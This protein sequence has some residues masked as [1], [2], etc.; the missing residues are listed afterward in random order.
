MSSPSPNTLRWTGLAA[1]WLA[2]AGCDPKVS[3]SGASAGYGYKDA[4]A[5]T[6]SIDPER[7]DAPP[8]IAPGPTLPT[9]DAAETAPPMAGACP[10]GAAPPP[11]SCATLGVMIDPAFAADY[12]CF[13]L[14]PVPGVP[15]AMKYG[16]L[17]LG[18]ES[19]SDTLIIGGDANLP[20]GKLYAIKVK[21][22]ATGHVAG[23]EGTGAV[24]ADAPFNDGGVAWGPGG[25]LFIT[26]WPSNELQL[27]KPGSRIAD[28]TIALTGLGVVHASASLGFVPAGLPGASALKLVTW[29]SGRW[30]TLAF[31][32]D[33]MGT[34][35]VTAARPGVT[36]PGGPEGFVYVAAGSPRFDRHA[37]LVSE[38]TANNISTYTID[39]GG[40]P[41]I[42]SRRSFMTGLSGAEG[43]YREPATGDFFFS[44]WGQD[45][46]RVI[47][48]RGFRPIQID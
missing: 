7:V 25:V 36:L 16:G 29:S 20:T 33:G 23:F 26:R 35:N 37:L 30:Y 46:D 43:A 24:H 40:D 31:A 18:N 5:E 42:A 17:T 11:R 22:D 1:A 21:R 2:A 45:E 38:W 19:C 44:T 28:K 34:F 39:D 10:P 13:D 15:N 6:A 41:V 4:G 9:A 32:P 48:V 47:V 8:P 12:T 14:G 3:V 27:T